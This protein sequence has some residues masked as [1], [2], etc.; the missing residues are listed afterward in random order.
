M[1]PLFLDEQRVASVFT[2]AGALKLA[3]Q[4]FGLLG[5]GQARMPSKIYLDLPEG[6]DFRAM[7]AWV[8]GKGGGACG[9]KWVS[10]FPG[11][12]KRGLPTVGATI[13]LN[14]ARTGEL[15]AVLAGGAITAL[16]TAATA[17]LAAQLMARQDTRTVALIGAGLQARYQLKALLPLYTLSKVRVWGAIKGEAD[18]FCSSFDGPKTMLEPSPDIESAVKEADL[19]VTCTPSRAP[20]VQAR[21]VR[22]GTHINAIGADAPGKQELDPR[23]L[24]TSRVVVDERGQAVHSGEINVPISR[25]LY[26]ERRVHAS[27]ADLVVGRRKGRSGPRQITVFDS[28]G[29]AVLDIHFAR[30]AYHAL[31]DRIRT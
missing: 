5:H 30:Y 20:L 11:N 14:S 28:T 13:L 22:P 1:R 6:D 25:G 4:V 24:T 2:E 21:W 19:I 18:R 3:R 31:R 17:A 12:R 29:L 8:G 9:V 7:P 10:V 23:I 27:L 15:Q 26:S 16:R